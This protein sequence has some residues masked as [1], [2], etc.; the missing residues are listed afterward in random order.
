M[1]HLSCTMNHHRHS[2]NHLIHLPFFFLIIVSGIMCHVTCNSMSVSIKSRNHVSSRAY[3][4]SPIIYH[5]S[6]IIYHHLSSIIYHVSSSVFIIYHLSCITYHVPRTICIYRNLRKQD[7]RIETSKSNHGTSSI[8]DRRIVSKSRSEPSSECA[9]SGMLSLGKKKVPT[10]PVGFFDPTR[11][12]WTSK[13]SLTCIFFWNHS[14][15]YI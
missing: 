12:K 4:L 3:H 6:S 7:F 13:W 1:Q 8:S 14:L 11:I 5:L 2:H 15:L 10:P 9:G